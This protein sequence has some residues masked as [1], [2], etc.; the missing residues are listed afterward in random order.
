MLTYVC[1]PADP[2]KRAD[3]T[4]DVD[5]STQLNQIL[6][7]FEFATGNAKDLSKRQFEV[8]PLDVCQ[9]R[10]NF[11]PP[12]C[13]GEFCDWNTLGCLAGCCVACGGC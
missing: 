2:V 5:T 10:C 13:F 9:D 4:V 8:C 1:L 12:F 3:A 6:K 7:G 11:T